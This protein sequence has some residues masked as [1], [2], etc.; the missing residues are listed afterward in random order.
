MKML[1]LG[2]LALQAAPRTDYA[3]Q[4]DVRSRQSCDAGGCVETDWAYNIRLEPTADN[5]MRCPTPGNYVECAESP[6]RVSQRGAFAFFEVP[7]QAVFSS[8]G[9]DRSLVEVQFTG[10]STFFSYGT[11][12]EGPP[13]AIRHRLTP[14]PR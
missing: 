3:W 10:T 9:P 2:L 14:P 8:I 5:Y 4:C 11:C 6:A 12:V 7:A 13:P 1:F